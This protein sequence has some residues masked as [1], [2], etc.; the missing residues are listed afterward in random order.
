MVVVTVHATQFHVLAVNLKHLAHT[1]HTLHAQMVV[2]VLIVAV[3][4]QC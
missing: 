1:F 2:E 4:L 3:I